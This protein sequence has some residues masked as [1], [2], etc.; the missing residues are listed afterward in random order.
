MIRPIPS[1]YIISQR[2]KI[3]QPRVASN[4][5]PWAGRLRDGLSA[6]QNAHRVNNDSDNSFILHISQRDK[7]NQ[8][9]VARNELPWAGRRIE[10]LNPERVESVPN[11]A[12]VT[13]NLVSPQQLPKLILKRHLAM[14]LFLPGNVIAH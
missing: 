4:E 13:F 5:L 6:T 2:D 7:I 10:I 9:R 1:S 8:P 14:M 3:N 12:F 11:V